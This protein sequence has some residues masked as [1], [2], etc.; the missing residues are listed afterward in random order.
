MA[1][2]MVVGLKS[3]TKEEAAGEVGRLAEVG[4]A[5]PP[6]VISLVVGFEV[7]RLVP[8]APQTLVQSLARPILEYWPSHARGKQPPYTCRRNKTHPVDLSVLLE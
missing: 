1:A 3:S 8:G 2:T 4:V 6:S 7:D 5:V